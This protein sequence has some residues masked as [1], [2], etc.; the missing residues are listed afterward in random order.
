MHVI[1]RNLKTLNAQT[2][3]IIPIHEA[4]CEKHWKMA[5]LSQLIYDEVNENSGHPF[6]SVM[7]GQAHLRA[8]WGTGNILYFNR[9]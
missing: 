8:F 3:S 2:L 7:S 6:E 4:F 1:P 9:T 5:L